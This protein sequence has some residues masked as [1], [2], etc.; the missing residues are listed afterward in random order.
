MNRRTFGK[1]TFNLFAAAPLVTLAGLG[2]AHAETP[3][4]SNPDQ[5]ANTSAAPS[6]LSANKAADANKKNPLSDKSRESSVK[7]PGSDKSVESGVKNPLSNKSQEASGKA[8]GS[9]KFVEGGVKNPLSDKSRE[10]SVKAPGSD[11]SVE[12]GVKNPVLKPNG[13]TD[14]S[15]F[16]E[17]DKSV[18][19][20][21]LALSHVFSN[22]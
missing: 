21:Q 1:N 19:K 14:K 22:G 11:K 9:D 20:R 8:P 3:P 18:A 12:S 6:K 16:F 10:S 15:V 4:A 17:Q 13:K 7:V 5:V 2:L